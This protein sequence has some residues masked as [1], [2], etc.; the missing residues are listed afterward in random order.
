MARSTLLRWGVQSLAPTLM[1]RRSA[2]AGELGPRLAVDRSLWD[3]P[4][5]SYDAMRAQGDVIKGR[6]VYATASHAVASEVLR[7]PVF[8]V[9]INADSLAPFAR[10]MLALAVDPKHPGPAE[11]PSMLAVD[12]P[13]HTKYR[14]LVAKVFTARAVA[15]LEP[16]VEEIADEL[17]DRMSRQRSL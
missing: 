1:L 6:V 11:P 9:G 14:R 7:S 12:P 15:A 3:D 2:R 5:P 8:R 4:F 13:Q 10:R 17:L 16:R